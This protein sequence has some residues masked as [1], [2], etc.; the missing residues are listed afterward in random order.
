M[1]LTVHMIGNAHL[2]PVWLWTW[3]SGLDEALAT[4]RSA[5]DLLDEFPELYI[6]RGEAWV[7][8]QVQKID[9]ALF[10]RISTHV[11]DGR[12]QIVNGWWVQ[13][14]C[15]FPTAESFRKHAEIG[16]RYFR[17]NFGIAVTVGYNVDSFGHCAMLPAFLREAG[18][19]NYVFMRPQEHE[20][21]LPCNLFTWQSP[22]GESV[23]A[24]R[25][26]HAYTC[27]TIAELESGLSD[28][29]AAANREVGHTMC[30]YGVGDHGGGPTHEQIEWIRE[31]A[32]Y[33][34]DVEL[35][36]SHPRA[37]FDAVKASGV[38]LPVV[39]GE[40]QYHAVGCYSVVH[41]V[42]QEM[43]RAEHLAMQAERLIQAYP[44][45][46][47]SADRELLN[48][49]WKHILFN[50][51]HDTMG[52][53][54]IKPAY[55]H[56]RDELGLAKTISRRIIVD[57]TRKN[58]IALE[59]CP[60][61]QLLLTNASF[62]HFRGFVE[63]EP[64]LG[65][66]PN[67]TPLRLTDKDGK[68][69]PFQRIQPDSTL[70]T[71]VRHQIAADIPPLG[72]QVIEVHHDRE[73]SFPSEV[74]A[75]DQSLSNSELKIECNT[76]GI[77]DV[78]LKNNAQRLIKPEGIRIAA[79]EDTTDTWSHGIAGYNGKLV[80]TFTST[81]SWAVMEQG[82]LRITMVN[83]FQLGRSS[84]LWRVILQAGEPAIRMRLRLHWQGEQT[85][86]KMIIPP[87]FIPMSRL[88]GYPGGQVERA[89][90]GREYPVQGCVALV[91]GEASIAV[92]SH[93][94]F[95]SDVQPDGSMQ[96][97]L[98][99]SPH[100]AHHE[101]FKL[102]SVHAYPLTDQGVHE[103]EVALLPMCS[104]SQ[105]VIE[106]EMN[107]QTNPVWISETTKGM[108]QRTYE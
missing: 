28:A 64:W 97:T 87:A 39:T 10:A 81:E 7:Y 63:F 32:Q 52:G 79:F 43:R 56:T 85:I 94:V 13:P 44:D 67:S 58:T 50:Q 30:F 2:D 106:E 107:R 27:R 75:C 21:D 86:V 1:K 101:P 65:Y 69:I 12:W 100:Y 88:D 60:Y 96:L 35:R 59:P 57:I 70:E 49:A 11:A 72:Q 51:F 29:I 77:S 68:S 24:F 9:P 99:R 55:E 73:E 4:C 31:H 45:K 3:Q 71:Q 41:E 92:V 62:Q 26:S 5:C 16:G 95:G 20:K 66:K 98:L 46:I 54:A 53:T 37:F 82:P 80:G 36:F 108:P 25:I 48:E 104:F 76:T 105:D 38:N 83:T 23:T 19:D 47:N 6:T 84:L 103:Y 8:A 102:P 74:E 33:T 89:M 15:N 42:K 14:D 61:Q 78:R 91:G 90:D 22:A 18:M 17:D 34:D 40:L 93:D